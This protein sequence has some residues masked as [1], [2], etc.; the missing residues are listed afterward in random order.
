MKMTRADSQYC[1]LICMVQEE[2]DRLVTRNAEVLSCVDALGASFTEAPVV[3]LRRTAVRKA[4]REMEWFMSGDMKCPE[5]LLDWWGGQLSP[6]GKL[7]L[8]YGYQLRN[9]CGAMLSGPESFDGFD[10]VKFILDGLRSNPNS[11]RLALTTWNPEDMADITVINGNPNTPT[12]CHNT[13]TQFFVRNGKLSMTTYQRS[14]DILLGVP[15]N[16]IQSWAMLTWFAFHANLQVGK[17]NWVF[18]DAHLYQEESHVECARQIVDAAVNAEDIEEIG[19]KLDYYWHGGMD[20]FDPSMPAFLASD[21]A[22]VGD[23]PEPA[24]TVRPKL[25]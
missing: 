1:D 25:L 19:F 13:L 14:A 7:L 16:W 20:K 15:H 5:E 10:Q 21:F 2:G 24:V 4:I 23:V 18:G 12:C 6:Q 3:T 9:F 11:R 22:L 8:G 17:M